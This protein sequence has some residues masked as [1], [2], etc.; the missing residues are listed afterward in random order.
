M[1]RFDVGG[2]H[3]EWDGE[4]AASNL[5]KHG[6]SFL[7]AATAFGD[8]LSFTIPDPTPTERRDYER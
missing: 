1:V 2:L 4:K 6:V 5:K 8:D 7:E 3:F